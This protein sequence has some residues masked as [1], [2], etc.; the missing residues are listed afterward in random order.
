MSYLKAHRLKVK[1]WEKVPMKMETKGKSG[2][3]TYNRQ[4][5]P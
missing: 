4:D 3:N 5:R 2:S 1:R